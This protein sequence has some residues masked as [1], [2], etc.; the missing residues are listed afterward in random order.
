MMNG[1]YIIAYVNSRRNKLAV[2]R[3]TVIPAKESVPVTIKL[4]VYDT[5]VIKFPKMS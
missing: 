1:V 3:E 2:K 4:S 5:K